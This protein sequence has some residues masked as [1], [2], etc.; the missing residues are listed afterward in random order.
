MN[1]KEPQLVKINTESATMPCLMTISCFRHEKLQ[2]L[3]LVCYYYY[4]C[5]LIFMVL[6]WCF[7]MVEGNE[8]EENEGK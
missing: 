1:V 2:M 3:L 4:L 5:H 6:R 7:Y 8:W